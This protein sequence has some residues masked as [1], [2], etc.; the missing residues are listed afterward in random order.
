MKRRR[1]RYAWDQPAPP[2]TPAST[3]VVVRMDD[4]RLLDTI[5]TSAAWQLGHGAWLVCV[6]G[7][8]GGYSLDR[9]ALRSEVVR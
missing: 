1:D 7:I 5:T 3:P 8:K 6:D 9:V 2:S 4:G